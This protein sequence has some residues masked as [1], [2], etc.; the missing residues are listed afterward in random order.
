M[1]NGSH[2]ELSP[3]EMMVAFKGR[4]ILKVSNHKE[5][6]NMAIKY[7]LLYKVWVRLKICLNYSTTSS[8]T[9]FTS[10]PLEIKTLSKKYSSPSLCV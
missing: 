1:L 4:S 2:K 9:S 7:L 3:D 5:T 6:D 10:K 8:V